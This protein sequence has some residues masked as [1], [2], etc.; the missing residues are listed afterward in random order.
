[1]LAGFSS[2]TRILAAFAYR[3]RLASPWTAGLL[4][5][6]GTRLRGIEHLANLL[7]QRMRRERLLQ[8]RRAFDQE[9]MTD[10]FACV[11]RHVQ[12]AY[13]RSCDDESVQQWRSF[14]FGHDDVAQQQVD[15][16]GEP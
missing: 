16:P 11:A 10:G 6:R 9:H 3:V 1:M 8:K 13:R 14:R 15:R 12:H 4:G 2:T 7:R 5:P